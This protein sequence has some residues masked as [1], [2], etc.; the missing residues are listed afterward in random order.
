MSIPMAIRKR[1]I[2]TFLTDIHGTDSDDP[3]SGEMITMALDAVQEIAGMTGKL[4]P[5]TTPFDNERSNDYAG[6][7]MDSRRCA[8]RP[9]GAF[10][11]RW[12]GVGAVTMIGFVR[13]VVGESTVLSG[14]SP[15]CAGF[16]G[17]GR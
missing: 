13:V 2:V 8:S 9:Y 17:M 11:G 7:Q 3:V 14:F 12:A 4:T 15:L 5:L 16:G 1:V 10:S 6:S